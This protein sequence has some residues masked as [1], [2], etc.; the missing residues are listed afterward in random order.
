MSH[1][2]NPIVVDMGHNSQT[3]V[4]QQNRVFADLSQKTSKRAYKIAVF[5]NI[6]LARNFLLQF[7]LFDFFILTAEKLGI[8]LDEG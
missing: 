8:K 7:G 1:A 4:I 2:A 3:I 6:G 5:F